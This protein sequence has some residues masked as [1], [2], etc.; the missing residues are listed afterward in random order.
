[1]HQHMT[2]LESILGRYWPYSSQRALVDLLMNFGG[3]TGQFEPIR[4]IVPPS[5]RYR[6]SVRNIAFFHNNLRTACGSIDDVDRGRAGRVKGR[7]RL[8]AIAGV[9][10]GRSTV[11]TFVPTRIAH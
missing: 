11:P 8:E 10:E 9:F 2:G 6:L 4:N 3:R 5:S 7:R 1:A